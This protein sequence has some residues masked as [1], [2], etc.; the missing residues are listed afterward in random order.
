M[1]MRL[2]ICIFTPKISATHSRDQKYQQKLKIFNNGVYGFFGE[3]EVMEVQGVK[4]LDITY[5]K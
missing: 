2:A 5:L 1:I 4:T 3:R